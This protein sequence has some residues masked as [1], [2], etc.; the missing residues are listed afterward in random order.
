LGTILDVTDQKNSFHALQESE[1]RFKTIANTAP[2]MIWMSGEDRFVNFFNTSWLDFTG[3]TID[4]ERNNGWIK[5]VHPDDKDY[6]QEIYNRAHAARRPFSMEFRL[7]RRDGVYRWIS[8]SS[9]PRF[10]GNG[11][12]LGFISACRDIDDE[13]RFNQML[14][15][16][17]LLF[18]TIT[19]VAP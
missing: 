2:V 17:E 4:Q 9:V 18:K 12:F 6:C 11:G 14:Q 8:G 10:D 5:S 15:E 3:R 19:N 13:R 7:R 1:E 16:S